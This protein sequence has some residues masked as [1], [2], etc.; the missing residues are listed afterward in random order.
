[1]IP[2]MK[3]VFRDSKLPVVGCK[4]SWLAIVTIFNLLFFGLYPN[5]PHPEPWIAIVTA[6]SSCF[7]LSKVPKLSLMHSKRS[8][9]GAPPPLGLRFFQKMEWLMWPPPLNLRAG[10]SVIICDTSSEN[11]YKPTLESLARY[12]LHKFILQ[13]CMCS[14]PVG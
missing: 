3:L 2:T 9:F 10:C 13:I 14:H 7:M 4:G 1:M 12:L 6:D 5:Q 11:T 8:P